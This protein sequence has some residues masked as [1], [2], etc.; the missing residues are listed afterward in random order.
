[1]LDYIPE[2]PAALD[3]ASHAKR[4]DWIRLELLRRYGG[5]WVDASSILTSLPGLGVDAV[6]THTR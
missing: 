5:I 4:A 2:I 6:H 1:M 3:S